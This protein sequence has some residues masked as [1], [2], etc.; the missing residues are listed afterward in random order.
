MM[1]SK[2]ADHCRTDRENRDAE[3][4]PANLAPEEEQRRLL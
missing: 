1:E 4:W 3:E 2:F